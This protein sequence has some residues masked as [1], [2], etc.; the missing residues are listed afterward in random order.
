M[1][2]LRNK[3]FTKVANFAETPSVIA[4]AGATSFMKKP[5]AFVSVAALS[6]TMLVIVSSAAIWQHDAHLLGRRYNFPGP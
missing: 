6:A 5:L 3:L 2:N 1:N 4:N